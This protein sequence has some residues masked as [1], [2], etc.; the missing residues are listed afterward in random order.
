MPTNDKWYGGKWIR[1]DL[2]LAIY[3]RDHFECCYCG[4]DLHGA[5]PGDLHLDHL[6]C[7]SEG[8]SNAPHNLIT[9]CRRCNCQRGNKPWREYA[10]GGSVHRIERN[11]RRKI[12]RYRILAKSLIEDGHTATTIQRPIRRNER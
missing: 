4:K 2:R 5:D 1:A 8:G 3:L 11:R 6:I 10:P 9:A 12:N 7:R